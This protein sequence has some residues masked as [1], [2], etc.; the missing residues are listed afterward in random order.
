LYASAAEYRRGEHRAEEP[1]IAQMGADLIAYT[2]PS[3]GCIAKNTK[4]GHRNGH[5]D[6]AIES[7]RRDIGTVSDFVVTRY[8][9]RG[10]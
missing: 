8:Q 7:G 9:P 1:Q 4:I 6:I 10:D 3:Q 2:A 5:K